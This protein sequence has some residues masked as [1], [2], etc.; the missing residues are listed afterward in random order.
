[1]VWTNCRRYCNVQWC[2]TRDVPFEEWVAGQFHSK[3]TESLA[4]SKRRASRA[5][6]ARG[7]PKKKATVKMHTLPSHEAAVASA[8]P[9][10]DAVTSAPGS[11]QNDTPSVP[12]QTKCRK[13]KM[14]G[15]RCRRLRGI[16]WCEGNDP[17]F[18]IWESDIYPHLKVAA[19]RAAVKRAAR[20]TG[21]R[22]RPM[23]VQQA[24]EQNDVAGTPT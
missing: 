11:L 21:I 10:A 16:Q 19:K 13:C 8:V 6:G 3:K 12:K 7:R 5:G 23:Q 1:M 20:A 15:A 24:I 17:A 2:E 22:G 9:A 18:D 14:V 4:R